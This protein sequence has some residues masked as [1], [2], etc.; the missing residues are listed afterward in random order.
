MSRRTER[1]NEA[2]Q[3][4]LEYTYDIMRDA[5]Q[6][7]HANGDTHSSRTARKAL[8]RVDCQMRRSNVA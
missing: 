3:R 2:R 1:S 5:L 8:N 6:V 7:V 4:V